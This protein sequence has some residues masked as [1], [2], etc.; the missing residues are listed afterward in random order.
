MSI[1]WFVPRFSVSGEH[2]V[3]SHNMGMSYFYLGRLKEA[4]EC[5]ERGLE[6][7]EVFCFSCFSYPRY[8]VL[9]VP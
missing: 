8:Q 1:A 5:F 4:K 2:H 9:V 7:D 6:L 3:T